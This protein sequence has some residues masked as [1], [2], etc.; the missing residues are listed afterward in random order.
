MTSGFD[1]GDGKVFGF[2]FGCGRGLWIRMG[3]GSRFEGEVGLGELGSV[4][5]VCWIW[6]WCCAL[7][8]N[9]RCWLSFSSRLCGF[10]VMFWK[11]IWLN[12]CLIEYVECNLFFLI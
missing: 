4:T 10:G 5:V 7:A 2:D 8:V 3:S 11:W 6:W 1:F 9:G 12:L